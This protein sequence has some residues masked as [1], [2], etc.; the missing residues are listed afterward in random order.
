MP[1]K[2]V[3]YKY[4]FRLCKLNEPN[5]CFS[6]KPMTK[7]QVIKQQKAIGISE[8]LK[9]YGIPNN[10]KLYDEIK[11]K[12]YED[13]PKHSLFRSALIQKIYQSEGGKYTNDKLPKMNIDKW[14][15]QKWISLNDYL[16]GDIVPCGNSNKKYGEYPLCR[17]LKIA[18]KLSDNEIKEM[19]KEKNKLKEKPLITEKVINRKDLNIKPTLKGFGKPFICRIG[20][21]NLLKKTIVNDYFINGY[22]NMTYVEPFI[23]AGNIYFYKNPS[24]NEVI[25]D[26]DKDIV[27]LFKGMKKYD[28]D[29]ISKSI[30]NKYTKEEFNIIKKSNPK[31]KYD[32]F[33]KK[34]LL[35]KLSFFGKGKAFGKSYINS[36][37]KDTYNKRMKDTI[38]LNEDYNKVINEYDSDNTF[39]YLDPPYQ[40][41]TKLYKHD[42]VDINNIYNI[43]S[44]IK[45]KFLMSYNYSPEAIKLFKDYYIYVIKT[46]YTDVK[47]GGQ[48]KEKKELLISNYKV[49]NKQTITK[50][51]IKESNI[52]NSK[53][54]KQLEKLGI[55]PNK[56]LKIARETGK[57]A[58]YNP[59]E[60]IFSKN[61]THKL[62]YKGVSFGAVN[63]ND[64]IIYKLTKPNEAEMKRTNYRKR[65]FK[66]MKETND[67]NSPA[68]LSY[69]I[70]W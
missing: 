29:D 61:N 22:E 49:P 59:K 33:I 18:E 47:K 27:E 11:I 41:S 25:N 57:K 36:N 45:G 54:I 20:G 26:L 38:I 63:Y 3:K 4:G 64:Y 51:E 55:E 42:M 21:K 40:S 58:G 24:I 5:K 62:E 60:I 23:G 67:K 7:K 17:P 15:K 68:S 46:K 52:N 56:Y 30:N 31:T 13:N 53:F 12:V 37:Y 65:A 70:L 32:K 39:F 69:Y 35:Y 44:K 10:K 43:L 28:G 1:Y 50:D 9:G 14:F 8:H 48:N 2:I 16:R 19:I 66:V 34:L 6:N